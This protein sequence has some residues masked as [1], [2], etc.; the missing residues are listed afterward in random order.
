M[1]NMELKDAKACKHQTLSGT[2]GY[3][4]KFIHVQI[5]IWLTYSQQW[6]FRIIPHFL[7]QWLS[8]YLPISLIPLIVYH[9]HLGFPESM[10]ASVLNLPQLW[11][12][13]IWSCWMEHMEAPTPSPKIISVSDPKTNPEQAPFTCL[14]WRWQSFPLASRL[15]EAWRRPRLGRKTS[16]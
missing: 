14:S 15:G 2:W 11:E 4:N 13:E 9:N 1:D 8:D 12:W 10:S 3:T 16:E 6:D 5:S 7:S